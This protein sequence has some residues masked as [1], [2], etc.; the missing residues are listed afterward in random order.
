MPLTR[1]DTMVRIPEGVVSAIR[2]TDKEY[3]LFSNYITDRLGIRMPESKRNM[4]QGRLE[5]RL[6]NLGLNVHQYQDLVFGNSPEAEKERVHFFDIVTTN[7]TDFFREERHFE[8]LTDS[9]L[10]ELDERDG[11]PSRFSYRHWCAGCSSG[12]EVYTTAMV[13]SEYAAKRKGFEWSLLATD[14]STRVLQSAQQGIYAEELIRP[15]AMPLRKKYMMRGKGSQAGKIRFIPALRKQLRFA[16][17]N[18]MDANYPIDEQIDVI[19]FRNV[20]IY[21]DNETKEKVINRM[22]R[23]LR[24]QGYLFVGHTESLINLNVPL[25]QLSA[26][27]YQ[28]LD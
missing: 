6:R 27:V 26:A 1:W 13:L 18:F 28:K 12:E 16:R 2:L 11:R 14:I 25:K 5:R 17:L 3:T 21:F 8:V 23:L 9:V 4:L 15:V 20:M 7:K 19:F 22:C 24:P 10:P